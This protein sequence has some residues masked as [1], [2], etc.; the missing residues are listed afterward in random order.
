MPRGYRC[1]ILA[2]VGWLILAAAPN[3]QSDNRDYQTRTQRETEQ[4][5]AGIATAIKET[6]KNSQPDAGC[7]PGRDDR[8]SDLCAQWKAADAANN[9]FWLGVV[10]TAIG[11]MT[12]AAAVFAAWYA[13]H[14]AVE[15]RRSANAAER[16]IAFADDAGRQER[17][18][19]IIYSTMNVGR[20]ADNEFY[21]MIPMWEN[22]G[23]SPAIV[24][25][26]KTNV[27][28]T[29]ENTVPVF[30]KA[31]KNMAGGDGVM[32]PGKV[33]GNAWFGPI[34]E[35]QAVFEGERFLFLNTRVEYTDYRRSYPAHT[36][37]TYICQPRK[38]WE[39]F[40]R[41]GGDDSFSFQARGPQN[42]LS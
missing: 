31:P 23:L 13:R 15:T 32:G 37:V 26:T 9:T 29:V 34:T 4:G 21:F 40:I 38:S 11:F 25:Y 7:E 30:T 42:S 1:I 22:A 12:L 18:P 6:N 24:N 19:W 35:L 33:M 2:F 5:L 39:D 8:H 17:R 14:A 20:T 10:G 41:T 28:V 27:I 36:E 16:A 3:H